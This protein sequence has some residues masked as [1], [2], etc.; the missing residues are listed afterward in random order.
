MASVAVFR[1]GQLVAEDSALAERNAGARCL[2]ILDRLVPRESLIE[3]DGFLAD[4][5]PGSF[6]GVRV[7]VTLAKTL[8]FSFGVQAAGADAFDLVSKHKTV[9]LPS[10]RDEFFVRQDGSEPIRTSSYPPDAI[11]YGGDL[12]PTYPSA[13]NFGPLL[14]SIEWHAPELLVPAYL[15]EPSISVPKRPIPGAIPNAQ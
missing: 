8:A 12:E 11:G 6:T 15:I 1:E 10:K 5:G 9:A 7:G 2:E 4:L 14:G 13:A 3:A